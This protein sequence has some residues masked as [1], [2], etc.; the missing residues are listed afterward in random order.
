MNLYPG[1]SL[2]LREFIKEYN[3]LLMFSQSLYNRSAVSESI[4]PTS[5]AR[6]FILHLLRALATESLTFCLNDSA[7]QT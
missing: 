7:G 6:S 3:I 2:A 1:W 5:E 4:K